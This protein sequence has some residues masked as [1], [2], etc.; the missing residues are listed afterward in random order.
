MDMY[1]K[2]YRRALLYELI[3]QAG[4]KPII[5]TAK[6]KTTWGNRVSFSTLR[7]YIPGVKTKRICDHVNILRIDVE[8]YWTL[9]DMDFNHLFY[10]IGKPEIYYTKNVLRCGLH[11]VKNFSI[12]PIFAPHERHCYLTPR[13]IAQTYQVEPAAFKRPGPSGAM[14]ER[15]DEETPFAP[16]L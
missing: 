12:P 13:I 2:N 7:P 14:A 11:L 8:Q 9:R 1:E 15:D 10:L 16:P 5:F 3:G 6:Y 4:N